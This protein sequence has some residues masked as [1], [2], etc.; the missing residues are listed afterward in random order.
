MNLTAFKT[1]AL[2]F[3]ITSAIVISSCKKEK[4]EP[5]ATRKELLTNKWKVTD[6]QTSTG[7]SIIDLVPQTQCLKDNTITLVADNTFVLAEGADVCDTP[8]EGTGT[9]SLIEGETK[10]KFEFLDDDTLEAA[11]NDINTTTL[12]IS[13]YFEDAPIPDTYII[14]LQK[15]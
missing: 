6:L 5:Q 2:L 13:Y 8:L 3:I 11:I 1:T 15:Q 7:S 12:K 14:V 10:L 4:D 9:W